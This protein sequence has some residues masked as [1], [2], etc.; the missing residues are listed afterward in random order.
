MSNEPFVI[1]RML[2]APSKAV[3]EA[4][5]D[6]DKM[7]QWYFDI[8][9]FEPKVGFEFTFTGSK[10]DTTY[11]HLCKITE[12]ISGKKLSYSWRYKGYEGDSHLTWELFPEGNK[13]KLKLTHAGLHS[14]PST[15]DSAFAV[16]SFA[17]GWEYI[18]GK[19]LPEYLEKAA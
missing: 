17:G 10:D 11:V 5:T 3:W 9:A 6:K 12:V 15:I 16:E 13:T 8:T 7:K 1:E 2:N 14:F 19:S 4:I 18:I